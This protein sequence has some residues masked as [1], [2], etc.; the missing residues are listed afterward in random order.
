MLNIFE[1][2]IAIDIFIIW[3]FLKG[4]IKKEEL[5]KYAKVDLKKVP[6]WIIN[7]ELNKEQWTD[8]K[9]RMDNKIPQKLKDLNVK[10]N[11]VPYY[12]Q[13]FGR[14]IKYPNGSEKIEILPAKFGLFVE[15]MFWAKEVLGCGEAV[16][17]K[18]EEYA[19]Q[20]ICCAAV[21]QGQIISH[22]SEFTKPSMF[23]FSTNL[24]SICY[25]FII[26]LLK[27]SSKFVKNLILFHY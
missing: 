21:A 2:L 5:L 4:L 22:L 23:F 9:T 12:Y 20:G 7:G 11:W 14:K 27:F 24:L 18:L 16:I 6:E 3:P 17:Y 10:H 26:N 1:H 8:Y 13:F 19:K 25:E 15:V